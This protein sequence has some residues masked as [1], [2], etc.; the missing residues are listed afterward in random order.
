M[1]YLHIFPRSLGIQI[2][3]LDP[4]TTIFSVS[5]IVSIV[6]ELNLLQKS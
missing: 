1:V 3:F 6:A 2:C 4:L 5:V